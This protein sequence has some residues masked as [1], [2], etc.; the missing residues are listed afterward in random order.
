M[1]CRALD[2]VISGHTGGAWALAALPDGRLLSGSFDGTL[3]VWD[4]R[5]LSVRGGGGAGSDTCAARLPGPSGI[6]ALAVL[7]DGHVVSGDIGGVLRA[8][9]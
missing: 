3:R 8:W 9:R 1:Q 6:F 2:V 7:P 4:E 5:A